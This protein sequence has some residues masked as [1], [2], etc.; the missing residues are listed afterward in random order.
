MSETWQ[1]IQERGQQSVGVWGQWN[2]TFTVGNDTLTILDTRVQALPG[3]AQAVKT[4]E[5]AV[6]DARAARNTRVALITLLAVQMPRKLDGDLTEEDPYHKD[7]LDIRG[8]EITGIDTAQTRGQMVF[9]LWTKLNARLAAETPAKPA[10]LVGGKT[11]AN[12]DTAMTELPGKE[13]AVVNAVSL[14]NDKRATLRTGMRTTDS[15]NKRWYAAWQGEYAE[16]TPE[17]DALSQIDTGSPEGGGSPPPPPPPPPPPA[18]PTNVTFT[19]ANPGDAVEGNSDGSTGATIF[20][21]YHKP[22]GASDTPALVAS[23]SALPTSFSIS[24]GDYEFTMTAGNASGESAPS[25]PVTL[26]VA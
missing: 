17:R 20:R 26:T 25:A 2:P 1:T 22:V 23:A 10:L 3:A 6:D 9:S 11:V 8:T 19:Q 21:V 12:L 15:L 16:G 13:Q 7:L 5:D 4:Q 18:T 24:P 14:L